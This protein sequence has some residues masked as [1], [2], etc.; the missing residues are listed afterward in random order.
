MLLWQWGD[1]STL[2]QKHM[3]LPSRLSF[4]SGRREFLRLSCVF[5][6][7]VSLHS[8]V[9][10]NP[11]MASQF[12]VERLREPHYQ[13]VKVWPWCQYSAANCSENLFSH[14]THLVSP[15]TLCYSA[16]LCTVLLCRKRLVPLCPCKVILLS[17]LLPGLRAEPR[18]PLLLAKHIPPP[19]QPQP[20]QTANTIALKCEDIKTKASNLL[21]S[22]QSSCGYKVFRRDTK[23][24]KR[25][26]ELHAHIG[27][28]GIVERKL[29]TRHVN[30]IVRSSGMK[31]CA[32]SNIYSSCLLTCVFY[33]RREWWNT[34]P[35]NRPTKPSP[36]SH[37]V[38]SSPAAPV[39]QISNAIFTV[40]QSSH[41]TT[42]LPSPRKPHHLARDG[43]HLTAPEGFHTYW[44]K[45]LYSSVISVILRYQIELNIQ[46]SSL[47]TRQCNLSSCVVCTI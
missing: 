4:L 34:S 25:N 42:A 43:A 29:Q 41:A 10:R 24:A 26:N 6:Q 22:P 18:P 21:W 9:L 2:P 39:L 40:H 19:S 7:N 14:F 8:S 28:W 32:H 47:Y 20:L 30:R 12:R 11:S 1:I 36:V 44:N 46:W 38:C 27:T 3:V 37:R 13:V 15:W 5:V 45:C 16:C 33:L 23:G 31:N 17:A 35:L